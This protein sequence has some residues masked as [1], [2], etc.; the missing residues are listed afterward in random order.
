MEPAAKANFQFTQRETS[1][2]VGASNLNLPDGTVLTVSLSGGDVLVMLVFGGKAGQL[3]SP[4]PLVHPGELITISA[5]GS[6]IISG[7]F[8]DPSNL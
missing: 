3:L 4:S 8:Q 2:A 1:L 5:G 6:I 7:T